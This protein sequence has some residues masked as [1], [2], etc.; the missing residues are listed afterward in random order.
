MS[1]AIEHAKESIEH[2][3][4]A[5]HAEGHSAARWIA[6]LIAVLAAALAI[7]DMAAKSSQ[8]AYLTHHIAVSNDYAFFQAKNARATIRASEASILES[9]PN[10]AGN[11]AIQKKIAEARAQEARLRDEPG[12]DGMKQLAEKAKLDTALREAAAHSY[13]A[14]EF[15]VGL[16]QIAIVLASVSVVTRM[17]VLAYG[18]GL[19]GGGAAIYGGLI[20][21]HVV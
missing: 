19:L 18:A 4:H 9:L 16:L 10:A 13:H 14:F 12:Q 15:V 6:V 21:L 20:A 17:N 1:E 7:C 8:N 11:D 2:A 3:H 5:Q